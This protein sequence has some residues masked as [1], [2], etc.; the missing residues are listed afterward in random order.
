MRFLTV[1]RLSSLPDSYR[2]YVQSRSKFQL[3]LLRKSTNSLPNVYG[4]I[5]E[6]EEVSHSKPRTCRSFHYF[7]CDKVSR[8]YIILALH[9]SMYSSLSKLFIN[10]CC[11]VIKWCLTFCNPMDCCVPGFPVLHN[12]VSNSIPLW[13]PQGG[14][15]P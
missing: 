2:H 10:C 7:S 12:Q 5:R 1:K 11:L 3:E 9:L 13:S 8:P 15:G 6:K 4:R 14:G